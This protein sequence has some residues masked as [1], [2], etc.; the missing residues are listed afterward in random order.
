MP[1]SESVKF[2]KSCMEHYK[3]T[4]KNAE[5]QEEEKIKKNSR[6]LHELVVQEIFQV[7]S[8][9]GKSILCSHTPESEICIGGT[10][11]SYKTGYMQELELKVYPRNKKVPVRTL[12]FYGI[13]PVVQGNIIRAFIPA[14]EEISPLFYNHKKHYQSRHLKEREEAVQI[15]LLALE[16]EIIRTDHSISYAKYA[17]K[18]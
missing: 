14:Y 2:E 16:E 4:I 1:L 15:D 11:P 6:L 5:K 18:I 9:I 13:S 7:N 8:V 3:I 12:E 10:S 17:P